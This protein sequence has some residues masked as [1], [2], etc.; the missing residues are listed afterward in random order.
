MPSAQ[1]EL[2]EPAAVNPTV[3]KIKG[4]LQE[5]WDVSQ[6]ENKIFIT[7]RSPVSF[8]T[9]VSLPSFEDLRNEMI[10]ERKREYEYKIT[11][12]LG[13]RLSIEK[14]REFETLNSKTE[15]ELG[16][17][18]DRMSNFK[19]KDDYTPK[20]PKDE[21]LYNE[22]KQA[23]RNLPYKR[24]P[25]LY[26]NQNSIYIKTSR[27]YRS[28]FYYPREES[29]CRAVLENI[30]SFAESYKRKNNLDG[31]SSVSEN[32]VSTTFKGGREYDKY[33]HNKEMN[34]RGDN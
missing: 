22:Y 20:T 31:Y 2:K 17:L 11:L 25:D 24:L 34:L 13:E 7:R 8:Y 12:E 27:Y 15:S 28:A 3:A 19:S 32:R 29:E 30:Y 21:A 14:Y 4:V 33:L 18:K 10:E 23:L 16:E 9:A 6:S 5:G 26:D 1:D